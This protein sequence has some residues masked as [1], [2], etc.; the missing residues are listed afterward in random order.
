M[1]RKGG[2]LRQEGT[3]EAM[4][5]PAGSPPGRGKRPPEAEISSRLSKVIYFEGVKV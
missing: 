2:L 3:C 5:K 1:K 4:A